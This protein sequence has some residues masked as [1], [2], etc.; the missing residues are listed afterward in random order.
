MDEKQRNIA[1]V[2]EVERSIKYLKKGLGELQQ[3]SA[4]NDF[5]DPAMLFLS[6]GLERLFKSMLCLNF[7]DRYER[8][9][10]S[11]EI[12]NNKQGHD[13]QFLKQKIEQIC[14][15][16]A[17]PIAKTD[18]SII[19]ND[20]EINAI[21][22]VLSEFAKRSRYFNLDI[23]LGKNQA[24]D[25]SR[26]WEK[27]ESQVSLKHYGKSRHFE[28]ITDQNMLEKMIQNSN[29][30]LVSRLEMF[31][32]ALARQFIFG[33]FSN[34]SKMFAFQIQDFSDLEDSELGKRDYRAN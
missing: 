26:E 24:F 23:I 18:Y 8:F 7:K 32:R 10:N 15:P 31:F 2:L 30:L 20:L 33:G 14:I 34:Q 11:G 25:F 16:I 28:M 6:G 3:I 21:C 9:P 12:W 19:V 13:I 4:D 5:F 27:I 22:K 29:V 17:I 1:V